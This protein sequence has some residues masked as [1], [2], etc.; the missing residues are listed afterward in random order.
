M[1]MDIQFEIVDEPSGNAEWFTFTLTE[2]SE[3]TD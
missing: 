2:E 1:N 3:W